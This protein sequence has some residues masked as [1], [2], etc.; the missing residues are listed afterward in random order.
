L[1]FTAANSTSAVLAANIVVTPAINGSYNYSSIPYSP[2]ATS[3]TSISLSDDQVS[4]A[5]PIG[6]NF[7]F[8]G[9]TYSQFYISSNGFI[10]FSPGSSTGC[11]AG[12]VLPT[13]GLP[14]NLIAAAWDDLYPPG[15]G[16]ISYYTTGSAGSR[17]AV[18]SYTNIPYCCGSTPA[19]TTQIILHEGSNNIEIQTANINNGAPVTQGVQNAGA[20]VGVATPGMNAASVNATNFGTLFSPTGTCT[21][22]SK[23]FTITAN[24]TPNASASP[25]TQTLPCSG[26]AIG[27]IGLNSNVSGTSFNWTRDNISSVTGIASIGSSNPITGSLTNT[28]GSTKQVTFTITPSYTNGGTTCPGPTT[29][30][31]VDVPTT[32]SATASVTN[33]LNN[34]AYP[35]AGQELQTIY[36]NYPNSAQ[37]ETITVT[38]A[39][40]T[41]SYTYAWQKSNCLANNTGIP[42]F[43]ALTSGSPAVPVTTNAYTWSPTAL[44]TCSFF[45][46]N[47]YAF[48]VTVSDANGCVATA[49]K[50]LSVVN[51]WTGASGTSN[52]QICH[53]VPRSSLTQILQVSPSLVAS[54]LGHG[55]DLG[56]CSPFSGKQ[57]LP[58]HAEERYAFIYPN[59]TTGV[60]VLEIDQ[61]REQANVTVTDISGKVIQTRAIKA[62]GAK[63]AT[64]DMSSYAKGVYLVQVVD[65]AFV[66]RDKIVVH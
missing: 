33:A 58:E 19:V 20:T 36:L 11:C 30:A 52:V 28:S 60:F 14:D 42:S 55:D 47:V 46:D 37:S 39:G 40:G 54:H 26:Q 16:S 62:D 12:G 35:M 6:F 8:F 53:H 44:D 31:T 51:P 13:G 63:T 66:Y 50:K 24:P 10:T 22:T 4:G 7:N 56:N 29:T 1:S 9:N 49:T 38:G 21:G 61:I 15:A 48:K 27:N 34:T 59:P 65:G 45:G 41:G 17:K 43:V 2:L 3:G 25:A 5:I 18:V 23:S 64:F 57:I 32:V